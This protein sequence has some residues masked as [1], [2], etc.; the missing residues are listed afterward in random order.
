LVKARVK[1]VCL[2]TATLN[3]VSRFDFTSLLICNYALLCVTL[4]LVGFPCLT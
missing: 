3:L 1:S 4:P 2:L